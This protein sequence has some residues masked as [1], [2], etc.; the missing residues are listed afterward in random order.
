MGLVVHIM[1]GALGLLIMAALAF[2]GSVHLLTP[3]HILLYQLV[4]IIPGFVV[5]MWT[6]AI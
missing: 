5:T 4:W 3:I 1:G 2:L 6:R